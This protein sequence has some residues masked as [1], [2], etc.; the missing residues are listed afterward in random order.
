MTQEGSIITD[1]MK[2][3]IGVEG[4]P[5][6]LEVEKGHIK[7][8]AEAIGDPNPQWQDKEYAKKTK[9]GGIIAPPIFLCN[10]RAGTGRGVQMKSP[11]LRALAGGDELEYFQPVRPGDVI[12]S[13]SKIAEYNER[14]GR[15]GKMLFTII[16]TTYKNQRGEVVAIGRSTYISY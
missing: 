15:R 7:M 11:F 10:A 12:T 9:Y 6:V 13:V 14:E 2:A 4:A 8:V 1:E 5:T 16:E 3:L